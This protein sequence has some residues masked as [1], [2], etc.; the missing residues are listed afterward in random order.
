MKPRCQ[1]CGD[2]KPLNALGVCRWRHGCEHR[3]FQ[4]TERMRRLQEEM[5]AAER[6]R[7]LFSGGL[8]SREAFLFGSLWPDDSDTT[9]DVRWGEDDEI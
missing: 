6:G 7:R 4:H 3:Q 2:T 5:D 1:Q 8:V 9:W